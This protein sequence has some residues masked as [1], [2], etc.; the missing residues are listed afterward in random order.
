MPY[1]G[2]LRK[3]FDNETKSGKQN[4]SVIIDT[5]EKGDVKFTLWKWEYAGKPSEANPEPIADV[6]TMEGKRVVFDATSGK[7]KDEETGD[8][9][10]STIDMIRLEEPMPEKSIREMMEEIDSEEPPEVDSKPSQT[11]LIPEAVEE[12]TKAAKDDLRTLTMTAI[13]AEMKAHEARVAM[14]LE[15]ERIARGRA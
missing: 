2:T 3:I 9:W 4:W 5:D 8:R 12:P 15:V 13:N 1:R 10:P 11:D 6:H 14:L 7:V